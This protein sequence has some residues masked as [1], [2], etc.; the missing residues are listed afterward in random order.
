MKYFYENLHLRIL[1]IKCVKSAFLILLLIFY[2]T[3]NK[4]YIQEGNKVRLV[5]ENNTKSIKHK[6]L[7]INLKKL[8]KNFVL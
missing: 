3:E 5:G 8:L 4:D 6:G 2:F 1:C 7:L